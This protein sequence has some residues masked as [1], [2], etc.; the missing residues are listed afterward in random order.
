MGPGE[1]PSYGKVEKALSLVARTH[2]MEDQTRAVILVDYNRLLEKKNHF[3]STI[4][5]ERQINEQKHTYAPKLLRSKQGFFFF[6]SAR[7]LNIASTCQLFHAK[8][9]KIMEMV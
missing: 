5:R 6:L 3:S 7:Q 8:Q 9:K 2:D 1:H 4:D